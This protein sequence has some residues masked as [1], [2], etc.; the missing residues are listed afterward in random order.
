MVTSGGRR[1]LSVVRSEHL[2]FDL[3]NGPD[4]PP[5]FN[6]LM[7]Q[8]KAAQYKAHM[9]ISLDPQPTLALVCSAPIPTA[10]PM[11]GS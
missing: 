7:A 11:K 3:L 9:V 1:Q 4:S 2:C 6:D 10:N 8:Y 5:K